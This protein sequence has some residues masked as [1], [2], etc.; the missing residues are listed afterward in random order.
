MQH[1]AETTGLKPPS[2]KR[3]KNEAIEVGE[4]NQIP[5][6]SSHCTLSIHWDSEHEEHR[7]EPFKHNI[8]AFPKSL[9]SIVT[10]RLVPQGQACG[11]LKHV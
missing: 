11:S 9:Q 7:R 4:T 6:K 1:Y 8:R 10:E 3:L 2:K 5:Q